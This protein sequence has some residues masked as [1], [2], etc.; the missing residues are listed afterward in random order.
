MGDPAA[1]CQT[2][3]TVGAIHPKNQILLECCSNSSQNH[4]VSYINASVLMNIKAG[5]TDVIA[6]Q[7]AKSHSEMYNSCIIVQD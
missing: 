2:Y 7:I 5:S 1:T 4:R 3:N 6:H